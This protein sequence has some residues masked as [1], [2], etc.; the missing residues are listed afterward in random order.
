MAGSLDRCGWLDQ[1]S[2]EPAEQER[3]LQQLFDTKDQAKNPGR[4]SC[5]RAHK[6]RKGSDME[7]LGRVSK[8]SLGATGSLSAELV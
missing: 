1:M 6:A 5:R 3:A 7:D 2:V 4:S 8:H